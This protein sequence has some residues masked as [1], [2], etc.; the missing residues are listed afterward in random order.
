MR[1]AADRALVIA[2]AASI[3]LHLAIF[4]ALPVWRELTALLPPE[5][6]PLIA[7]VVPSAPLPPPAPAR[8]MRKP[9]APAP[10]VREPDVA[11]ASAPAPELAPAPPAP[12]P[13]P[14]P[15]PTLAPAPVIVAP[16]PS[17]SAPVIDPGALDRYRQ[18]VIGQAVRFKRYPR[19]AI[20][21]NWQGEVVVRMTIGADG[22]IA[23]LRV[24]RS[25]GHEV[26]DRQAL[27][28][29]RNAKDVVQVPGE[30]RGREFELELRAVYSLRDQRSG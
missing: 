22:R 10:A 27:E 9:A 2:F 18:G 23:A 26:L 4:G 15:A 28:M 20:D 30:L 11:P 7:R 19:A 1:G 16:A 5:P 12:V 8:E 6:V 29:F 3:L 21:N 25:S 24:K 14:D 17:P 13:A